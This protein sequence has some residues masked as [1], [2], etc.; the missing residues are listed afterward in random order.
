MDINETRGAADNTQGMSFAGAV[1][2]PSQQ[3]VLSQLSDECEEL[4][5]NLKQLASAVLLMADG[6]YKSGES[7]NHESGALYHITGCLEEMSDQAAALL[8]LSWT[9]RWTEPA[10]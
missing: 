4:I 6:L 8:A 3:E 5:S 2:P 10:A 9:A 7:G 1:H